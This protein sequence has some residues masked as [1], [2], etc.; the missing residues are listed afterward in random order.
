MKTTAPRHYVVKPNQ[1]VLDP[2]ARVTVDITLIPS[3]ENNTDDNKF[4]V[5]VAPCSFTNSESNRLQGFWDTLDKKAS[6]NFKLKVTVD[7]APS[8]SLR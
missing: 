5:Q 1:G 8:A 4:L 6:T 2:G 7:K 3:A